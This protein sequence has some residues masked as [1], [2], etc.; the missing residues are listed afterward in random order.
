[1]SMHFVSG[2]TGKTGGDVVRR[3]LAAGHGV[4]TIARS[5][6][7]A[8]ALTAA[9]LDVLV[10]DG[11]DAALLARAVEGVD[12][13]V[14]IY[15]NGPEQAEL[16]RALLDASVAAGV[17]H[18]V[19]LSSMEAMRR[20][21]NPV[22]RAHFESEGRIRESGIAWTMIRPNFYMQNFL[23][24]AVTIRSEGRFYLPMGAGQAAMTHTGDV[25]EVIALVLTQPGH[26]NQVYELTGPEVLSFT[27]VA[28]RFSSVLGRKVE[29][30]DQ[31]PEAFR[32]HLARF[33]KSAWQLDAVCDIFRGIREGYV[34][35]PT[36][37]FQMLTCRPP[38]SLTDFIV[39][40]RGLFS[41]A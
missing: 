11:S 8:A 22:H 6:E 31:D 41:M 1:M 32:Q 30:V 18:I 15:P 20:N 24:N 34:A 28:D 4:R 21:S 7:K 40:N 25:S 36:G 17:P 26:E 23:P 27:D 3:L 14:V 13:V 37:T 16:E 2:A 35:S 33:V 12:K 39:E 19:K 10:G 29:Y 5:T 38:R 9:G